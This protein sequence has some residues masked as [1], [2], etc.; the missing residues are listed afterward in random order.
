M[1]DFITHAFMDELDK[2]GGQ[3]LKDWAIFNKPHRAKRIA[4]VGLG[5]LAKSPLAALILGLGVGSTVFGRKKEAASALEDEL[6][7]LAYTEAKPGEAQYAAVRRAAGVKRD[8]PKGEAQKSTLGRAIMNR[9]NRPP[10]ARQTQVF[11]RPTLKMA[12]AFEEEWAKLA[13]RTPMRAPGS[14]MQGFGQ[15][16]APKGPDGNRRMMIGGRQSQI[17]DSTGGSL[18]RPNIPVPGTTKPPVAKPIKKKLV[19][20]KIALRR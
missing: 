10:G 20:P 6:G 4:K 13:M 3:P 11:K 14:S 18:K 15:P 17:G 5:K 9:A 19:V 7:K 1:N 16:W 8:I 12:A 2:L